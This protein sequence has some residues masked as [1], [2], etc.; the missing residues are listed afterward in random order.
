MSR[1][2]APST[3]KPSLP[4]ELPRRRSRHR[5]IDDASMD[6]TPMIDVTFLLLIFFLVASRMVPGRDIQLPT[7]RSGTAITAQTAITLTI[8]TPETQDQ[9]V[10]VY[11]GDG[12]NPE[13]L[14]QANNLAGQEQLVSDFVQ[15]QLLEKPTHR[16]VLLKAERAVKHRDVAR[17]ARIASQAG[18]LPLFVA[19]EEMR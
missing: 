13:A 5:S 17:V 4:V 11:R 14:L 6:I 3:S 15:Q 12:K 7:A 1:H 16:R 19:V 18:D 8:T 9:L 10:R 2:M